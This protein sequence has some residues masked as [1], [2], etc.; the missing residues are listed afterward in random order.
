MIIPQQRVNVVSTFWDFEK[1]KKNLN[2]NRFKL[3][4][5]S[6]FKWRKLFN[7][8][9]WKFLL[10]MF[11][12]FS[13]NSMRNRFIFVIFEFFFLFFFQVKKKVKKTGSL[14]IG[15]Q[16]ILTNFYNGLTSKGSLNWN[17]GNDLCGQSG[18]VC[19]SSNPKRVYQLYSYFF[20]FFLFLFLSSLNQKLFLH[21]CSSKQILGMLIPIN[22]QEQSQPNL[23]I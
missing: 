23:E 7:K 5:I 14:E 22:Y 16:T 11:T 15:E 10:W 1:E 9:K 2:K 20:I 17:V 18:V 8:I 13:W 12:I 6:V 21:Y 3:S 19:D 4:N